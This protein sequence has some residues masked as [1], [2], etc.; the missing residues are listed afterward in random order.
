MLKRYLL[1]RGCKLD[2]G[3]GWND[4]VKSYDTQEE[5]VLKDIN[6]WYQ[7]VDSTTGEIVEE[8]DPVTYRHRT[9]S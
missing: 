2:R 7:I 5:I 6:D 9:Y 4:F 1:F 8:I 3:G